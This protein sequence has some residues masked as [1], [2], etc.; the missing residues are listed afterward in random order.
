MKPIVKPIR[1]WKKEKGNVP[2]IVLMGNWL[3][4]IGWGIGKTYEIVAVGKEIRLK[5]ID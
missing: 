1:A 5:R 4:A 2:A 3:E